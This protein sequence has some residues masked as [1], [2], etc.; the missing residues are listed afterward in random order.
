VG[1]GIE[2]LRPLGIRGA[3][4]LSCVNDLLA[5]ETTKD[6][7]NEML[8]LIATAI[9]QTDHGVRN[10]I[11]TVEDDYQVQFIGELWGSAYSQPV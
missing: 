1:N 7:G 9:G 3:L 2:A 10:L 8:K 4:E 5:D 6:Q 11:Q